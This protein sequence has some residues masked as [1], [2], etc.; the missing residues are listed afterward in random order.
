MTTRSDLVLA[1]LSTSEGAPWTPVQLQKIF[2]LLD[3]KIPHEFGG[4]LWAFAAYDYG[5]FDAGIYRTV[6][7]L[8]QH[9]LALV[10]GGSFNTMRTFRLTSSGQAQ[11]A[12]SLEDLSVAAQAYIRRLSAWV[13]SLSFTQLVSAVYKEF[14]DMRENSVFRD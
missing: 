10:D 1:V 7:G 3:K 14:P 13:R 12:R 11:G 9:E 8:Q 5:P 2:F 6:E 4:P